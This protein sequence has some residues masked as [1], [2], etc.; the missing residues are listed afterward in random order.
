LGWW[1]VV[2]VLSYVP[3]GVALCRFYTW[4]GGPGSRSEYTVCILFWP[5]IGLIV[6]PLVGLGYWLNDVGFFERCGRGWD[7]VLRLAG[8]EGSE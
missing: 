3:I 6:I 4:L 7:R 8:W 1:A 2:G 5:V